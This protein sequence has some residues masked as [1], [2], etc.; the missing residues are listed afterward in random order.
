MCGG[1]KKPPGPRA[2]EV[3]GEHRYVVLAYVRRRRPIWLT[4]VG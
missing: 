3:F 1:K 2:Q 4:G